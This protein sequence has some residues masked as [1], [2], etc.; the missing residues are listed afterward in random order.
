MK[1]GKITQQIDDLRKE[2]NSSMA[3]QLIELYDVDKTQYKNKKVDARSYISNE[4]QSYVL[5]KNVKD[6]GKNYP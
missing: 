3:A 6:K 5:I 1:R 4:K 2:M